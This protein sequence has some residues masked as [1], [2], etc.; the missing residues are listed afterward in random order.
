MSLVY[1]NLKI[2]EVKLVLEFQLCALDSFSEKLKI[3]LKPAKIS[4]KSAET[5]N[6]FEYTSLFRVFLWN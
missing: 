1:W 4:L 3:S 5:W 6:Q 2:T